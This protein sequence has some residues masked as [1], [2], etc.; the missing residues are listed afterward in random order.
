[1]T[2]PVKG[3]AGIF[4]EISDGAEVANNSVWNTGRAWS[5]ILIS[6]SANAHVHDNVLAWN[7][8]G[9]A[10]WS[11]DRADKVPTGTVGNQVFGNTI[12]VRN[13]ESVAIDWTQHGAGRLFDGS[14]QNGG[15]SNRYWA[16]GN[17]TG[18]LSLKRM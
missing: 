15:W 10:V 18:V 13:R 14:A 9:I 7:P 2:V 3:P 16:P 17:A 5:G 6:S 4:F 11:I 12:L 1:M 8:V